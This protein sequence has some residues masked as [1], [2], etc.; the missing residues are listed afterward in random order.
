MKKNGLPLL[1]LA[2]IG[3]QALADVAGN[4]GL[5]P[6]DQWPHWRGP[7]VNGV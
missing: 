4:A 2:V 6:H 5:N 1:A 7:L 3:A